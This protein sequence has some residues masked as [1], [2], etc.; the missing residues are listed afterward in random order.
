MEGGAEAFYTSRIP[1]RAAAA[2]ALRLAAAPEV[3]SLLGAAIT[4]ES[5]AQVR[6]AATFATSF[7]RR[8]GPLVEARM[9]AAKTDSVEYVR[10]DAIAQLRALPAKFRGH[11]RN[12]DTDR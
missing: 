9:Q 4:H 1:V 11:S 10:S 6:A 3:D 2:R 7:R 12:T 8:N 5:D